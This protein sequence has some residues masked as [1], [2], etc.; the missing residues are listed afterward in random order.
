MSDVKADTRSREL[1]PLNFVENS[2]KF[3]D[4]RRA[5]SLVLLAKTDHSINE[6]DARV[7]LAR[8]ETAFLSGNWGRYAVRKQCNV[9]RVD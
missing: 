2:R 1:I 6:M 7:H 5:L 9:S 8:G 3:S 4:C